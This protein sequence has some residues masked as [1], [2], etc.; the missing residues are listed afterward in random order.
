VR[1]ST[2]TESLHRHAFAPCDGVARYIGAEAE[3]IPVDRATGRVGPL[4][5]STVRRVATRDGWCEEPS[6]SGAPRFTLPDG[7]T[8]S[9]EPGGQIEYSSPPSRSASVVAA[10]I[11]EIFTRLQESAHD[12]GLTLRAVGIDPVTRPEC[13]PLRLGGRRYRSMDAYF[14]TLGPAGARM[15]RQTAAFQVSLDRGTDPGAEWRMLNALTP[16]VVAMFANSPTYASQDT[17]CTSF[18]AETWRTL[19]PT[20]TGI[21][22]GIEPAAEYVEFALH[23][24][25]LLLADDGDW[26]PF[27]EYLDDAAVGERE[28]AEHLT[29]LFPE[30][31][32]R[33][34]FEVRSADAIDPM[35]AVV[36]MAFLGGLLYD[37]NAACAARE[38]VGAP[39]YE[40]LVTAG[41]S[42]L[43]DPS[44]GAVA[45]ELTAI[46]LAG[47]RRLGREFIE[48][49]D[50]ERTEMF[51]A[52][53]TARGRS[54]ADD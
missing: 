40:R 35:W 51:V 34:A 6:A 54:P 50:L 19:D 5:L 25:A 10:G 11:G 32:P 29:T 44:I 49:I 45:A 26:R 14:S 20:R 47:C 37:A 16:Y 33:G 2:L 27:G 39:D 13:A 22:P 42:G 36:P 52:R 7:G 30:V 12:D 38:I 31:R 24:P 8:V 1:V 28:W 23:A 43:R 4:A 18:R 17:R 53:Y 21:F 3:W 15:M 48:P 41:R 46:A 9:F